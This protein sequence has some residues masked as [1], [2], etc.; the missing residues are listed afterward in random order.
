LKVF[1]SL[2]GGIAII[3]SRIANYGHQVTW[4][5]SYG[6]HYRGNITQQ[7]YRQHLLIGY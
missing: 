5:A 2:L 1:Q 6:Q 7:N 4:A 3:E